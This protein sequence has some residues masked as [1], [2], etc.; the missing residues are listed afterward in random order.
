[1]LEAAIK[2]AVHFFTFGMSIFLWVMFGI[3]LD[4]IRSRR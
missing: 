4:E 3:I 2:Q 1:M